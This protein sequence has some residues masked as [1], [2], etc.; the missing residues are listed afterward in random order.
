[1]K[2]NIK[3]Q[4]FSKVTHK[5]GWTK[6]KISDPINPHFKIWENKVLEGIQFRF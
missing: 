3:Q 5:N 2:D 4:N 6:Y 1:M